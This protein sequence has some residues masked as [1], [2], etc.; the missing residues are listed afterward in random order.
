MSGQ[1]FL[2]VYRV[3]LSAWLILLIAL[4]FSSS[5]ARASDDEFRFAIS[6][7]LLVDVNPQDVRAAVKVWSKV[8]ADE[9]G[10]SMSKSEM[11]LADGDIDISLRK[12]KSMALLMT[13]I[14]Y[15]RLS[16]HHSFDPIFTDGSGGMRA[17]R[18]VLL[19]HRDGEIR[20]LSDLKG[21]NLLIDGSMQSIMATPWLEVTLADAGLLSVKRLVRSI[22]VNLHPD[23]VVLPVFFRQADAC[24]VPRVTFDTMVSL[25]PQLGKQLRVLAESDE[26][27]A[28][29]IALRS[30]Y[31]PKF[32]PGLIRALESL[33]SSSVGRQILRIFRSERL[34]RTDAAELDPTVKLIR[35]YE[36]LKR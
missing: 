7:G 20:Q 33:H 28:A 34:R 26:L 6:R 16:E 30:D 21:K 13:S 14:D 9:R 4:V 29:V 12:D 31:Q 2:D 36:A 22:S 1:A 18:Y 15:A 5:N 17:Q 35:R 32:R 8:L 10:I 24:V 23:R 25:N 3:P 11:L 19:V 27:V